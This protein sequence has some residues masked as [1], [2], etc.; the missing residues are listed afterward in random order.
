MW[1]RLSERKLKVTGIDDQLKGFSLYSPQHKSYAHIILSSA[2]HRLLD[3]DF[4]FFLVAH[5]FS[6]GN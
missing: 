3:I 1:H 5:R 4:M 2:A 6:T